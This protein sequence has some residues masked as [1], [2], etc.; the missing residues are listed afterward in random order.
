MFNDDD[1][2]QHD[3]RLNVVYPDCINEHVHEMVEKL[4]QEVFL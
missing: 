3:D 2:D 4:F 1:V